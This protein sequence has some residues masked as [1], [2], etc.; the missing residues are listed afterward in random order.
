[1][2]AR[3]DRQSGT[4]WCFGVPPTVTAPAAN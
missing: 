4:D 1:L 3:A 2:G